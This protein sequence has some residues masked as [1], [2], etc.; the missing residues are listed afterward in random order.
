MTNKTITFP[1]YPFGKEAGFLKLR[2]LSSDLEDG[3]EIGIYV[4]TKSALKEGA[5]LTHLTINENSAH[6]IAI[7]SVLTVSNLRFD[8]GERQ[9][10]VK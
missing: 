2:F 3:E 4:P 8:Y 9:D 5:S 7:G 1:R 6:A 10:Q